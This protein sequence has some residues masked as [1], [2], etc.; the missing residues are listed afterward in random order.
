MQTTTLVSGVQLPAAMVYDPT[1]RLFFVEVNA[2]RLRVF[3]DG[4]LQPESV[5]EFPVHKG[6]ESGLLGLALDP[7]FQENHFIYVYY[8]EAEPARPEVG[9][10]NRVM[11]MVERDGRG[12][13]LTP[14]LDNLPINEVGAV[15]AHQGGALIF[16]RDGKL[17]I[18]M[19]ETGNPPM[20]QDP[21]S[22][23]GKILRINPDGSIPTDNPTAGSA[24]YASGLRN[25]WGFAMHPK[26]GAIYLSNNG[27]KSHDKIMLLQPGANYGWPVIEGHSEDGRFT[28]AVWDSGDAPDSR[29]GMTGLAIYEGEMFPELR[30]SLL[31][32]AFRTGKLR[33]LTL[34]GDALDAADSQLRLDPECRL[35][36]TI[37]P[38]GAIITS[39]IDK[40][41]RS[42][43]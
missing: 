2:G 10:R 31:F 36:I 25:P 7:A 30:G 28:N 9:T 22:P 38:D 35:G 27:N 23:L 42:S 43:Q 14:I 21:T 41:L 15:D 13:E 5:A 33:R 17:Y 20:A 32:C 1:G 40:I 16:G 37:A 29:N 19:G 24:I 3:K 39:S 6:S 34:S 8:S 4:G 26:T 18:S 11:R 12:T